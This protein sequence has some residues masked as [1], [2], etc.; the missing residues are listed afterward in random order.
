MAR[1]SPGCT[2]YAMGSQSYIVFEL[3]GSGADIG[4]KLSYRLKHSRRGS[5]VPAVAAVAGFDVVVD[6]LVDGH[7]HR[8]GLGHGHLHGLLNGHRV[9]LLDLDG[10][11]LLG[12]HVVGLLDGHLDGLD[13]FHGDLDDFL[14]VSQ[15]TVLFTVANWASE[16]RAYVWRQPPDGSAAPL[17][18]VNKTYL[19]EDGH[20][21]LDGD[22]LGH[23]VRHVDVGGHGHLHHLD[24]RRLRAVEHVHV[25]LDGLVAARVVA[26]AVAA[27]QRV[28]AAPAVVAAVEASVAEAGSRR[29]QRRG[30]HQGYGNLRNR[31][32]RTQHGQSWARW[33]EG[34]G[35]GVAGKCEA[36][37]DGVGMGREAMGMGEMDETEEGE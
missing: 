21:D 27:A 36:G 19:L 10:H 35:I 37:M 24:A 25:L 31:H 20:L 15:H 26:A 8:V 18:A 17:A 13:Y 6:V 1:S 22:G 5:L 14:S 28:A 16:Q 7:V 11:L 2:S 12:D 30:C 34:D 4:L 33:Y 32:A 3:R 9:G 23:G 29:R